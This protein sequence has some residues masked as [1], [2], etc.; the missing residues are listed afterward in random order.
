M[1]FFVFFKKGKLKWT[2]IPTLV[3]HSFYT[4][5]KNLA[6]RDCNHFTEPQNVMTYNFARGAQ[7][8]GNECLWN[9][10]NYVD[11]ISWQ[12][13]VNKKKAS[14][15]HVNIQRT[16]W[17]NYFNS[18]TAET[19]KVNGDRGNLQ[20]WAAER[21]LIQRGFFL[22]CLRNAPVQENSS[23]TSRCTFKAMAIK[24]KQ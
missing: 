21:R 4:Y 18:M 10:S 9:W 2:S 23:I 5:K 19:N 24:A 7:K 1:I 11:L 6:F 3:S 8:Q 14:Q 20:D 22:D 17:H 12:S 13:Q 15:L 16:E